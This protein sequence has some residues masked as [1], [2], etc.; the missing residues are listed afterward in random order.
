METT[1]AGNRTIEELRGD[2]WEAWKRRKQA[3]RDERNAERRLEEAI[4]LRHIEWSADD[5]FEEAVL[6]DES[7]DEESS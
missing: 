2:V 6:A 1:G 3:E 4:L 7:S 5:A